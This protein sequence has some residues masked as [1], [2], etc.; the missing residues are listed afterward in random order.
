MNT[1]NRNIRFIFGLKLKQLRFDMGYSLAVLSE[2]TGISKSYLNEIEKGKK[3]PKPEKI[4]KLSKALNTDYDELVSIRLKKNLSPISQL[5][6]TNILNELPLEFFGIGQSELLKLLSVAPTRLSAFVDSIIQIAKKYDIQVEQFFYAVLRSYQE[7]HD[8]YFPELENEAEIFRER[9]GIKPGSLSSIAILEKYL[10]TKCDYTIV[11]DGLSKYPEIKQLRYLWIKKDDGKNKLL[12]NKAISKTQL[13]FILGREAGFNYLKLYDRSSTSSWVHSHSFD[14]VLN[15]FKA[16]YFSSA[17]LLHERIFLRGLM[18]FIARKKFNRKGVIRLINNS[19]STP[20]AFLLRITSLVPYYLKF[21]DFF[22]FRY[23]HN[24]RDDGYHQTKELYASGMRNVPRIDL[25]SKACQRYAAIDS[26]KG[27]TSNISKETTVY[28]ITYINSGM[29]F[30]LVGITD[31]MK[32]SEQMNCY[33]GI[34]FLINKRFREKTMFVDDPDIPKITVD[35][36]WIKSTSDNCNDGL[37]NIATLKR[38]N[39]LNKI[40]KDLDSITLLEK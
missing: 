7:M 31:H 29:R 13:L 2:E 6:E 36:N 35:Y 17:I 1:G 40:R 33:T 16:Y 20:E 3:Y 34:G 22:F 11:Y 8:N 15:N 28:N 32:P 5:I 14:Q 18:A 38:E 4:I 10:I 25:F 21:N 9:I 30:L 19:S 27:K 37:E 26:L 23:N 24:L 12:L 39:L